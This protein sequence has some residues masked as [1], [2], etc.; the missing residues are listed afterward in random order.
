[1]T[2]PVNGSED[3]F[4]VPLTSRIAR[5][6]RPNPPDEDLVSAKFDTLASS[7]ARDAYL[8]LST[9]RTGS[10][11]LTELLAN[12]HLGL[13]HEYFH[14]SEYLQTL[15]KRWGAWSRGRIHKQRYME[16][17]AE[18]R[19]G[20]TGLLGIGLH[21]RHIPI[22]REFEPHLQPPV[23]KIFILRRRNLGAQLVSYAK[24]LASGS[25]SSHWRGRPEHEVGLAEM[26]AA[27]RSLLIQ[28]QIVDNFVSQQNVDVDEIYYEDLVSEPARILDRFGNFFP[29][30][31]TWNLETSTKKQAS[32]V[33]LDFDSVLESELKQAQKGLALNW[34]RRKIL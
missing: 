15:S 34:L 1:M 13:P 3:W 14:E 24:S 6:L 5:H 18:A 28:F 20:P 12:N 8:L 19:T 31:H 33:E 21:G 23:Q 17:L 10:T 2:A 16:K 7:P 9:P 26:G 29:S 32:L 27:L 4:T 25:W 11:L 22:F 30:G